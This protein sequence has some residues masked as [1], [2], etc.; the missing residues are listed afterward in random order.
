M[1]EERKKEHLV[2]KLNRL[3]DKSTKHGPNKDFL[4]KY[5]ETRLIP[6]GLKLKLGLTIGKQN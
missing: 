3:K 5:I 2:L 4:S 1:F 6:K